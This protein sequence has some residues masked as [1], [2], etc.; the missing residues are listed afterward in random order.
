[1]KKLNLLLLLIS[2][3]WGSFAQEIIKGIV[4]DSGGIPLPGVSVV[5]KGTQNGTSTDFDGVYQ[6][7]V[8]PNATLVFSYLGFKEQEIKVTGQ[9]SL[10]VIMKEDT[11][12]L[13]EIVIIGYGQQKKESVLSSISQVKGAELLET[14]SPNIA[15]ALSG[16]APGVNIVQSS[17][18]PGADDG[19]IF[20]RGNS[21]PLILVDGVEIVGGFSNI[22]PRDVESISILKDGGATAVYGIRGANGVVIITTKRGKIGKPIVSFTSEYTVKTLSDEPDVLGAYDAQSAFNVGILND[23]AY[24]KGYSSATDLAHWK[25]G[26]LPYLYADT[27]W[28]D[29]VLNKSASSFNQTVSVRGGTDFVKYYASAGYL[30]E[31]DIFKT[32]K[33]HNYNPEYTFD[34]YSFRANLDFTI[35]KTTKLKT[36]VSSRLEDR[37][38]A[39]GGKSPDVLQVYNLA[40]G[41]VPSIYPAE[42]M[43]QYPDPLF[44]GLVEERFSADNIYSTI[45]NSGATNTQKTVFSIDFELDQK[46]DFITKG[47]KFVGKYNYISTYT[48]QRKTTFASTFFLGRPNLYFLDR[49]GEWSGLDGDNV[50]EPVEYNVGNESVNWNSEIAYVNARLAYNR[51]FG[52]HNVTGLALFSRNKKITNTDFPY[53][54]EDWVG[55]AT[56]NYDARYFFSVSGAYNGDETFYTG[57]RF[58][59]FPSVEV[60]INLAKEKFVKDNIP[61]LNNFKVRY[62]YGQSGSKSGLG[63]N[64]WQYLSFYDYGTSKASQRLN[65]R[66][67]FGEDINNRITSIEVSQLGNTSLSWATVTKQNIGVDFGLFKNKISGEVD[68]FKDSRV[69]LI[70]RIQT[71]PGY[72]GSDAALPFANIGESESHGV[73]ISLTYKNTTSYGLKYSITGGYGFYENRILVSPSDGAGTPEYAK[74]AGKPSGSQ[75]LIQADGFF[76]NIDELV[77]YPVIAGNPGLGDYRYIDYNAN[78]DITAGVLEDQVRFDLPK[79]PKNSYSLKMNFAY[80]GWSLSALINGVEGHKGLINGNLAYLLPN[81]VASGLTE[82]LDYWTPT[83]TDAKYPALHAATDPNRSSVHSSRIVDLD[84]IKLRSLNLGYTFDMSNSK[85]ISNLKLYLNGSN[86]FTITNFIY[87]DPE[88]NSPGSYPILRRFNLGLNI[89]L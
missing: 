25:D 79:S 53:Y 1:M 67:W 21:D 10:N 31:G 78:G 9:A 5:E 64:R 3:S 47:L 19:Q 59:F 85:T 28:A 7:K 32:V 56:Y 89:S 71:V 62:S 36:S 46:L 26:D 24:D 65:S 57:E 20:I 29:A 40:P 45:N 37:N 73:D 84:Y 87:G 4:K 35:S 54:S 50:Q 33:Y 43:E 23:Q 68:F 6:V 16:I 34:R 69:D 39:G 72:F 86:L 61:A 2:I 48:S 52:L 55:R 8:S 18:Q 51:S 38:G 22:D 76:Q 58:Q 88:G 74:I 14:G 17:G 75:A 11:E 42:V 60:G 70:N 15:N 83:N 63:T 49:N 44:P 13:S 66:Y 82:Q 77:N 80:K 30:S 41:S 81:S 27:N 12:S